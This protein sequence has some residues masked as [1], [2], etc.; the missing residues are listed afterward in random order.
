MLKKSSVPADLAA[1]RETIACDQFDPKPE[2][3]RVKGGYKFRW[4]I[5]VEKRKA[6]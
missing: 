6:P 5:R 3:R 1:R 4:L 2:F